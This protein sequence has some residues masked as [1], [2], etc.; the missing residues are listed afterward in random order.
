MENLEEEDHLT[1]VAQ[2][3]LHALLLIHAQVVLPVLAAVHVLVV[4]DAE[5]EIDQLLLENCMA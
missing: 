5:E 2:V 1:M 3:I 4:A